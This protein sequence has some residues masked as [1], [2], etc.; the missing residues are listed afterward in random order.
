MAQ[1]ISR[2]ARTT[3]SGLLPAPAPLRLRLRTARAVRKHTPQPFFLRSADLQDDFEIRDPRP[4]PHS[5]R[6]TETRPRAAITLPKP[7]PIPALTPTDCPAAERAAK[8]RRSRMERARQTDT[9]P[10]PIVTAPYKERPPLQMA[11]LCQQNARTGIRWRKQR[12]SI[13]GRT[14]KRDLLFS[15]KKEKRA[16][17]YTGYPMKN[18]KKR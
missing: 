4:A 16:T 8:P 1:P 11:A 15:E 18:R 5:D 9:G 7:I 13:F 2:C 12:H 10:V 6:K 14:E 17:A 3:G